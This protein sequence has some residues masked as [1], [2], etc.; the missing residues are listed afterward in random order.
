MNFSVIAI[1]VTLFSSICFAETNLTVEKSVRVSSKTKFSVIRTGQVSQ[2]NITQMENGES[3]CAIENFSLKNLNFK[4]GD[5]IKASIRKLTFPNKS[6]RRYSVVDNR[7]Y[8]IFCDF[9]KLTTFDENKVVA[10]IN[11][12]LSGVMKVVEGL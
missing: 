10:E 11:S 8:S 5:V 1:V 7:N 6:I 4:K 9:T 2:E 3:Y 12:Y